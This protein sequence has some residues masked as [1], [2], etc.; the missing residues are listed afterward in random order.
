MESL[1]KINN[2]DLEHHRAGS[3][4]KATAELSLKAFDIAGI[5]LID[6]I[7]EKLRTTIGKLY[8]GG[9]SSSETKRI[10]TL[11]DIAN[12]VG[13]PSKRNPDSILYGRT[14]VFTGTLSSMVRFEAQKLVTDIA[15]IIG[16]SVTKD[17]DFLIVG[18]QD[19]RVVGDDGMSSKQEKAV[20]LIEQGSS[21]EVLSE[22]DFLRS[23]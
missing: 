11:K 14:I 2:I 10:S 4:S 19:Y 17:T 12:L 5:N 9:Y 7:P 20:K 22:D 6:D 3:D 13:D 23:I 8:Y 15:G 1:C 16:T 21:L 18:Q